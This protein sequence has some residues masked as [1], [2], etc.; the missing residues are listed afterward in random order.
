MK[1]NRLKF[2]KSEVI[3]L[4]TIISSLLLSCG[5]PDLTGTWRNKEG[6]TW[7]A[8]EDS[9]VNFMNV[10]GTYEQSS[11]EL[12]FIFDTTTLTFEYKLKN[13]L[14]SLKINDSEIILEK[15]EMEE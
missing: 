6:N 1:T 13:Q 10:V 9:E 3:L 11:N 12:I 14:L 4:I 8:F 5:Q 7:M 2:L 15:S